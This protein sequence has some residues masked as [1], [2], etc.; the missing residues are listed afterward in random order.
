MTSSNHIARILRHVLSLSLPPL[1]GACGGITTDDFEPVACGADGQIEYLAGVEPKASADYVELRRLADLAGG[2]PSAVASMGTKCVNATDKAAC[3]AKIAEVTADQGFLLGDCVDICMHHVLIVNTGDDVQ[4]LGT[5]EEVNAWL[6]PIDAPADAVLVASLAGYS[7][8]CNQPDLGGV[9]AV[10]STYEVLGTSY[11]SSCTPIEEKLFVLGVSEDGKLTEVESE[12][13]NSDASACVGRRPAGLS[14]SEGRGTSTVGAFFANV[15]RLEAASVYAFEALEEELLHHGAPAELVERARMARQDEV[16]HA[17]VMQRVSARH[18]GR[19]EEPRVEKRPVRSLEEIAIENAAEGCVRE[20]FGA[21][22]GMWQ[23]E[24]ARDGDVRRVMKRIAEDETRHA[25]L[26][27]AV[28]AWARQRL[29]PEAWA[30]VEEARREAL[31]E[32]AAEAERGYDDELV[33]IAGMP[34]QEAAVRL[35]M[36]FTGAIGQA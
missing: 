34:T 31:V 20:T 29:S 14:Q 21:L 16:R 30:R 12:V 13:I 25:E 22:V 8:A 1:V 23:A 24:F 36:H 6:G 17:R 18:G 11:T 27:W 28:D 33:E 7:V 4:V 19:F 26:S 5:R 2:G 15:A 3:E 32:I 10:G 9:R 35:A